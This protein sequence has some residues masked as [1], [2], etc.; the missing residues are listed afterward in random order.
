MINTE[1]NMLQSKMGHMGIWTVQ[2]R[3]SPFLDG[4]RLLLLSLLIFSRNIHP[5]GLRL[6][7]LDWSMDE[8]R[9]L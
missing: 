8:D 5:P 4:D 2:R 1:T 7:D 6:G 9:Q 3:L